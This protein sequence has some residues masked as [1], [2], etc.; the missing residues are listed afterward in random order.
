MAYQ[1]QIQIQATRGH[2][3]KGVAQLG[4]FLQMDV[5]LNY[6]VNRIK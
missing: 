4:D 3:N 5:E 2:S 6:I 1:W